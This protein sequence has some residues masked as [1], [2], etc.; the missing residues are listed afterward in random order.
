[1]KV[2]FLVSGAA[3]APVWYTGLHMILFM[4]SNW[5]SRAENVK[6]MRVGL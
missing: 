2:P 1:M 5:R 3:A 6:M 4:I